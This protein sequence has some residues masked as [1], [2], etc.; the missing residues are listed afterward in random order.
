MRASEKYFSEFLGT[1]ILLLSVVGSGIMGQN[2]SQNEGVVLL[3]NSL[4]IGFTLTFLIITFG[5]RSG[6]HFNPA[7]TL[8]MLLLKKIKLNEAII[9]IFMQ[10][11]G[12]CVGVLIANIIFGLDAIDL[13]SKYRSGFQLNLSE[14]LSTFGLLMIILLNQKNKTEV[15]A[16][17]VGLY[18]GAG[19]WF[20]SST[21]FAN[22]AVSI[23]RTLTDTFT[24]IHYSSII[25]FVLSQFLGAV[26]ALIILKKI[27]KI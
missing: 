27:Y 25:P 1:L 22:P 18:I 14:I 20:M 19:I 15:V 13:S 3:A 21:A 17:L 24:G 10:V 8:V 12:A 23:A 4:A 6:A 11:I 2:L 16:A 26:T 9:Y 5:K 7:V